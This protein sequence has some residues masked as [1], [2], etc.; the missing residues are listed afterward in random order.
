MVDAINAMEEEIS[1]LSDSQLRGKTEEFKK[2]II[3][4][5]AV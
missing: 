2:E 1:K 3:K 4:K 5:L